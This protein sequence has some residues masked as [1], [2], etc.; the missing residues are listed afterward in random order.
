MNE[1]VL[2]TEQSYAP[3]IALF[4]VQ[5]FFGTATV[6]G[7]FAL[8]AFPPNALV[9]F[10]VG[11]AALAFYVLQRF[12]GSLALENRRDYLTFALFAFFG[13]TLNQLLFFKGLSL[14]T[15]VNT[16]LLAVTIPI[17]TILISALLGYD[18]LS[19]RKIAGI[20]L[21]AVGVIYLINPTRAS[22]GSET[23]QGDILIVLNS[24]CYAGYVAVSKNLI[25]HYGALKSIAWLFLFASLI[26]VPLGIIS[27]QTVELAQ[28]SPSSWLFVAGL[29]VFPTIMAYFWNA[30]ALS[31]VEPSIV[32][33]YI[34]LQPL[35]GFLAA[36]F[37]LGE[38]FST[39]LLISALLVFSG[40]F[41]VTK[42]AFLRKEI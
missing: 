1:S 35:M 31:R 21:A 12:R 18:F 42:S 27:L 15:A 26:N 36:I 30:W 32:A 25:S 24:L 5:V 14:T 11:G 40:V 8:L 22:F 38:H 28:V 29:V 34:Y 41:L 16:S 33:V 20:I 3:H 4:A 13:V 2:Q 23:T 19:W 37:F 7:K 10:R 9:G 17:F 39:R 6:L